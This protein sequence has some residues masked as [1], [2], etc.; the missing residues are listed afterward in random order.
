MNPLNPL[1]HP[2]DTERKW[3]LHHN[4]EL[5]NADYDKS[6]TS[7]SGTP[8]ETYIKKKPQISSS[9]NVFYLREIQKLC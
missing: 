1:S 9:G 2:E 8:S 7:Q 5:C 6:I 3:A 4:S